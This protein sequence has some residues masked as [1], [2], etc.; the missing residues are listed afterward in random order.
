LAFNSS[1]RFF[2]VQVTDAGKIKYPDTRNSTPTGHRIATTITA[3]MVTQ[4]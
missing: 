1:I 3:K 2:C 4:I